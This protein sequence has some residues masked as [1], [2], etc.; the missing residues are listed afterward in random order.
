MRYVNFP[1]DVKEGDASKLGGKAYNL[2]KLIKAGFPVPECFFVNVD[3]YKKFLED[4]ALKEK[5]LERIEQIDFTNVNEIV[6]ASKEIKAWIVQAEVPKEVREEIIDA[7]RKLAKGELA[8]IDVSMVSSFKED[9]FVA[10]RSSATVEDIEKA[11]AAGQQET[12]LNIKGSWNVVES[13]KKCW[14]SLFTPRAIYY[15]HEKGLPQDAG[16]CVIVQKMVNSEKSGV[17]FTVNPANPQDKNITIEAVWG[18]GE[19]IVQGLVTPDRYIVDKETGQILE[20]HIGK[21]TIERIRDELGNTIEREVEPERVEK[22]VLSD[23]EIVLVAAYA[24]KIE[25]YYNFPQDIEFAV[26]KGKVYILQTRPVTFLEE[27]VEKREMKKTKGEGK[28]LLKGLG[29]SPG[30]ATGKVKIIRDLS[31]LGKIEKGD[32]LVTEMTSPDF[33]PAMEKSAAIITDRGGTTCHAAIVSREL[34]IPCIVGTQLA[35]KVLK[36]GQIVTV[37]ANNGI[38]YE[39]KIEIEE[40]KVEHVAAAYDIITATHIKVNLAFPEKATKELAEKT[41]GVGLL[42]IEHMLT[43]EGLHPIEYIRR[44]EKEKLIE[45]LERDI[46]KVAEVFYPKP[47]WVRSLDARTDEFRNMEGGEKE[48]KEDNPMLG[49]HGVRRSIEESD[50]LKCEFEAIKRLH[51]KGLTNVAIML[52]FVISVEELRKAKE[53]ARDVGLPKSVKFGIM[54][55]IP[56]CALTIEDFC[57]E[58]IDFISFGTNDLTQ[59]TLGIDRNN[60]KLTKIFSPFH[61]AVLKQMKYVIDICKKYGVETSICGEAGSDP[62]MAEIL[63]EYGIDS[64]SANID[65]VDKIRMAVARKERELILEGLRKST[66]RDEN[67]L[68]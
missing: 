51:T 54:V 38:V 19:T 22:Q 58:G 39:G 61:P 34:G 30:I 14:A 7:Y 28:I 66:S 48:P 55:E 24:K 68:I 20:K 26:E 41:D 16:I 57:K 32:I 43:K 56:A 44:G 27:D 45:I 9:L 53:I 1:K 25:E 59:L 13:V 52:P 18:L 10:V 2:A 64:I 67:S 3:A 6:N 5:I 23:E 15:R 47:V 35:T 17:I 8:N 46:G 60:E 36:D 31:E 12:F 4:N 40:K 65:A 29:A 11:S 37:D 33:V 63:V 21:K 62:K 42:R 50:I 49:W